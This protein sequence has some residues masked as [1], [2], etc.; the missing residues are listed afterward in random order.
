MYQGL[1]IDRIPNRKLNKPKFFLP[2]SYLSVITLGN[3]SNFWQS[4]ILVRKGKNNTFG[5]VHQSFKHCTKPQN[6]FTDADK[7]RN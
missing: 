7:C 4:S 3:Y 1:S 2:S 6:I 5:K